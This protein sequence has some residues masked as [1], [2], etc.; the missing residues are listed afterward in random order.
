[1][2][3]LKRAF[4]GWAI[5]LCASTACVARS[6]VDGTGASGTAAAPA[7]GVQHYVYFNI[8]RQRIH[9]PWFLASRTFA[10]AQLKYRWRELEPRRDTYDFSAI[11]ADLTHLQRH[12]KRLF[13]QLQDVS[14]DRSIVNV[15]AYLLTDTAFHGG[16][17]GQ[18]P[19]DQDSTSPQGFVARRWDPAV[20]ARYHM[21]LHAM[22]RELDG[23][24]EGINLPETA[25]EFGT[26]GRLHPPGF[27]PQRYRDAVIANMRALRSSFTRSIAMQY[28]NFMPGEWLPGDDKGYLRAVYDAA[29]EMKLSMGGPDLLP[30]RPGQR[31]HTYAM[32]RVYRGVAPMGIAVQWGNY[33]EIDP[34]TGVAITI[35]NLVDFATDSL[36]V[37]YIFWEPQEPF[38]TRDV[39]PLLKP[40]PASSHDAGI[41][42][43][44]DRASI[45]DHDWHSG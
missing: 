8:E 12:G 36:G 39:L 10:G 23:R 35:R 11:H 7:A 41:T 17:A 31:H 13:I 3:R 6:S 25:L 28:A 4:P 18:Y 45:S 9:E 5:L 38:F 26:T 22:A 44:N 14:F 40:E 21:L 1:M 20:R 42:S 34:R 27:T 32:M 16:I 43:V 33:E 29:R 19:S 2:Q 37:R 15:P 24:I 30:L